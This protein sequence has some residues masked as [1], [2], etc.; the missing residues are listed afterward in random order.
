M[1]RR[2]ALHHAEALYSDDGNYR[3]DLL[4]RWGEGRLLVGWLL[5]PSVA[6]EV[7]LDKSVSR[8][9]L[10]ADRLGLSGF[11]IINLF[12][13]RSTDPTAVPAEPADV[14]ETN[15]RITLKVLKEAAGDGSPVVA[16]WGEGGR[17]R[18]TWALDVAKRANVSLLRFGDLT[19]RYQSPRHPSRLGHD[20]RLMIW[21]Y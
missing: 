21:S 12:A 8:I 6:T 16:G 14:R 5:N 7:V 1:Q 18:Q 20:Q 17:H 2:S 9:M 10:E 11:R 3:Y 19:T 4:W 13:Y 15:E